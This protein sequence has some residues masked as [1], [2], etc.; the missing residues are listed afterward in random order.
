M[1]SLGFYTIVGNDHPDGKENHHRVE[2][3]HK[4]E[5]N[6]K[7]AQEDSQITD[8]AADKVNRGK[9]VCQIQHINTSIRVMRVMSLNY[10][11]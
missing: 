3:E 9:Y 6:Q 1:Q 10:W 2:G 5:W 7:G 11:K 4:E 8:K